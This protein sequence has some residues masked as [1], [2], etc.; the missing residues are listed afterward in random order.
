MAKDTPSMAKN[1]IK[2]S[3]GAIIDPHPTEREKTM[4]WEYF[5]NSCAYCGLTMERKSRLGHLDHV[6]PTSEGGNNSIFNH[7]LSCSICNGDEKRE[8]D[9]LE[10][11]TNKVDCAETLISRRSVIDMWLAKNT[12]K[13]I[14]S[15]AQEQ[16]DSIVEKALTQFDE[17]VRLMR[18]LRG[19]IT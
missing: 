8:M 13:P 4:L 5:N 7:V 1:K 16:I 18:E 11:L 19:K 12:M 3:L 2:R 15:A 9:W 17:S 6:I 14:D 10:F